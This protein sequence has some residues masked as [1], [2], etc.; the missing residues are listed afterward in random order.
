MTF[1]EFKEKIQDYYYITQYNC[2]DDLYGARMFPTTNGEYVKAGEYFDL[3]NLKIV[4][5]QIKTNTILISQ[6]PIL[7]RSILTIDNKNCCGVRVT[8]DNLSYSE[9]FLSCM[10]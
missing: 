6:R 5:R 7:P 8:S 10:S 4:T 9:I 1:D 3:Y 2:G